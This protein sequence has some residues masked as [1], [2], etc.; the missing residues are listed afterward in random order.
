VGKKGDHLQ[1]TVRG[2]GREFP[3]IGFKLAELSEVAA[4]LEP[5]DLACTLSLNEW[6]GRQEIQL[7]LKDL[8][9]HLQAEI[10]DEHPPESLM[11]WLYAQPEQLEQTARCVLEE[12]SGGGCPLSAGAGPALQIAAGAAL[13]FACRGTSVMLVGENSAGADAIARRLAEVI[14][15][16]GL[17]VWRVDAAT[18]PDEAAE[19]LA[20]LSETPG[21]LVTSA[22]FA[23]KCLPRLI[24]QRSVGLVVL[25][26]GL[27]PGGRLVPEIGRLIAQS[28]GPEERP[29]VLAFDHGLDHNNDWPGFLPGAAA[30]SG[31]LAGSPPGVK[32]LLEAAGGPVA[33]LAELL[34]DDR[35]TV[36]YCGSQQEAAILAKELERR[37]KRGQYLSCWREGLSWQHR[38]LAAGMH[39]SGLPPVLVTGGPVDIWLA[40]APERVVF[41][42]VDLPAA[43][44]ELRAWTGWPQQ[45]EVW[46]CPAATPQATGGERLT[47]EKLGQLYTALKRRANGGG[48]VHLTAKALE[49]L[50]RQCGCGRPAEDGKLA[51]AV[52]AELGLWRVK[53]AADSGRQVTLLAAPEQSWIWKLPG[54]TG[55]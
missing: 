3:C 45:P 7:R 33:G 13:T 37:L 55:K 43:E 17:P 51:L 16:L 44:R 53:P 5:V 12:L 19:I 22:R 14:S 50:A 23:D 21:L 46:R 42:R 31:P 30:V 32:E 18:L 11:P 41:W 15:P 27:S 34:D 1:M 36:V 38:R 4:G 40:G 20:A 26:A 54:V 49:Q 25:A 28:G 52:L 29:L 10:S 8:R 47:R 39:M 48:P 24:R 35:R 6:Q 2:E 9:S